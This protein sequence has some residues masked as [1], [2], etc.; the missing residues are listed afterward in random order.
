M[1]FAG[2]EE[3]T[4]ERASES[5]TDERKAKTIT[6]SAYQPAEFFTLR[7]DELCLFLSMSFT[8]QL[9][10]LSGSIRENSCRIEGRFLRTLEHK[11]FLDLLEP[12][13]GSEKSLACIWN[14]GGRL[15]YFEFLPKYKARMFASFSEIGLLILFRLS[16]G[17]RNMVGKLPSIMV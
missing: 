11:E 1:R 16:I 2:V 17:M 9:P 14:I 15:K 10:K 12:S 5:L 4:L 6:Q 7:A 3:R 8:V 13:V